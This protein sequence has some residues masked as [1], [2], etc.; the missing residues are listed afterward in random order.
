MKDKFHRVPND[1]SEKKG[2]KVLLSIGV[3]V[4]AVLLAAFTVLIIN[5]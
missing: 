2:K 1:N 3:G 4:L 5:L